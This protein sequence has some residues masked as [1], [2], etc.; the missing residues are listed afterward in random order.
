MTRCIFTIMHLSGNLLG[1][2]AI[3]SWTSWI[4]GQTWANPSS[5]KQSN[6]FG[7]PLDL[8]PHWMNLLSC[9][10]FGSFLFIRNSLYLELVFR[11]LPQCQRLRSLRGKWWVY[12]CRCCE[13]R[14]VENMWT[15]SSRKHS[16]WRQ[17][18][19]GALDR[20][21]ENMGKLTWM[22]PKKHHLQMVNMSR[23][24]LVYARVIL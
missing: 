21:R 10:N 23:S 9:H 8:Y 18:A 6:L 1:I 16:C 2:C 3:A 19:L 17:A 7:E 13:P 5:S 4:T 15:S 12:P 22:K 20:S 14:T 24:M 11:H